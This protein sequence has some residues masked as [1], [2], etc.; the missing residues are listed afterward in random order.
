[1]VFHQHRL[2]YLEQCLSTNLICVCVISYAMFKEE[3]WMIQKA[4][5]AN[6]GGFSSRADT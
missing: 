1:M 2:I 3:H 4:K 6:E 5:L